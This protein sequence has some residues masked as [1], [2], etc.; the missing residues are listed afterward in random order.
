MTLPTS[1]RP[2]WIAVALLV[3]AGGLAGG[4]V[5][6]ESPPPVV[7]TGDVDQAIPPTSSTS[8]TSTTTSTT[9]PL[10]FGG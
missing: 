2:R 7:R 3:A 5:K 4:C 10:H 9:T 6:A 8:T 1:P